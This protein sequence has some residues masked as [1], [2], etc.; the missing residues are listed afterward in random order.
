[1][2]EKVLQMHADRA[3][4]SA[5]DGANTIEEAIALVQ[6]GMQNYDVLQCVKNASSI[7]TGVSI[8]QLA[9]PEALRNF[10]KRSKKF[11]RENGD[12]VRGV[13][14]DYTGAYVPRLGIVNNKNVAK[15]LRRKVTSVIVAK[16][17][18][19]GKLRDRL[20]RPIPRYGK[21]AEILGAVV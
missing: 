19:R 4:Q 7:G 14:A 13:F 10:S 21:M 16:A 18:G 1:M 11:T 9:N 15:M 2:N 12:F 8:L 17:W 3:L 5:I 20:T 6:A